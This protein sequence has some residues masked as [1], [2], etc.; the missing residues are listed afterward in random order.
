MG[1][2]SLVWGVRS[3][4]VGI[5]QDVSADHTRDLGRVEAG[6]LIRLVDLVGTS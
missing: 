6:A 5:L 3:V 1:D 2:L 4:P